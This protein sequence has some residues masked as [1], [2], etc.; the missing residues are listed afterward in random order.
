MDHQLLG[1]RARI[2]PPPPRTSPGDAPRPAGCLGLHRR[3]PRDL[4]ARWKPAGR[5]ARQRGGRQLVPRSAGAAM[6]NRVEKASPS[7]TTLPRTPHAPPAPPGSTGGPR[8]LCRGRNTREKGA[9]L[10]IQRPAD[11]NR[12]AE[13]LIL[14]TRILKARINNFSWHYEPNARLPRRCAAGRGPAPRP[15]VSP[16][17]RW[18]VSP[19]SS[20]ESEP[21]GPVL[22]QS[23]TQTALKIG[24]AA[25]HDGLNRSTQLPHVRG[26]LP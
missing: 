17:A 7:D 5:S 19:P 15:I 4:C 3:G 20:R 14:V 6:Q 18:D 25:P 12:S 10:A 9:Q 2:Q 24:P 16:T 13:I 1:N 11:G 26:V 23:R 21:F 22:H 8:D